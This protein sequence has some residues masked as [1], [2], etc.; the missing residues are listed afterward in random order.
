MEEVNIFTDGGS[1]GNPG[2]AGIGVYI[3]DQNGKEI[4]SI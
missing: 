4:I 1:R 3:T 2:P